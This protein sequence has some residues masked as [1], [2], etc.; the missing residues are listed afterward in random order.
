M[1]K[2]GEKARNST[3]FVFFAIFDKVYI[4][5]LRATFWDSIWNIAYNTIW[6]LGDT[7]W[8]PEMQGWSR[9]FTLSSF[10]LVTFN[11]KRLSLSRVISLIKKIIDF[12]CTFPESSNDS[13]SARGWTFFAKIRSHACKIGFKMWHFRKTGNNFPHLMTS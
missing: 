8:T 11:E 2:V 7:Y 12:W 5:V 1:H 10:V 13:L 4:F 6:T 9:S 3:N